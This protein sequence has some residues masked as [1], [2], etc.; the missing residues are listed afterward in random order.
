MGKG[1]SNYMMCSDPGRKF[2]GL[3][4]DNFIFNDTKLTAANWLTQGRFQI[5]NVETPVFK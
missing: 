5:Q 3:V 2:D 1:Y 4:F